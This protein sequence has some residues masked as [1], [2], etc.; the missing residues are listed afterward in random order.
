VTRFDLT[1]GL[2]DGLDNDSQLLN[3]DENRNPARGRGLNGVKSAFDKSIEYVDDLR[4]MLYRHWTLYDSMYHSSYFASR[5]GI[6]KGKG[7]NYLVNLLAKIG[8]TL[9]SI[10]CRE[11]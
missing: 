9:F 11:M 10:F 3:D 2:S 4:L 6:W 1:G 8:Y 7:R 5:L